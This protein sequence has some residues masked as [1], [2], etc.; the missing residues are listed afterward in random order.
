MTSQL[1]A[2]SNVSVA[3]YR[4]L[5]DRLSYWFSSLR[6]AATPAERVRE[7][8]TVRRAARD[9]MAASCPRAKQSDIARAEGMIDQTASYLIRY[10]LTA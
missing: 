2:A 10:N 1:Q 4:D 9:L 3:E 6:S 7:A 8:D 5:I